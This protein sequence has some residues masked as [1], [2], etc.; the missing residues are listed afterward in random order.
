MQNNIVSI[1]PAYFK[2]RPGLFVI[3]QKKRLKAE[4][5]RVPYMMKT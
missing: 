5:L 1:P 2:A 3:A 4:T